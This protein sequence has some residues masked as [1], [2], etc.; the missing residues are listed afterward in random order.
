M[1]YSANTLS[2]Y[3][4]EN[5]FFHNMSK[6][7]F[8]LFPSRI[9]SQDKIDFIDKMSNSFASNMINLMSKWFDEKDSLP[10]QNNNP[11]T[12][13]KNA[14]IKRNTKEFNI[15]I[16]D[17]LD[18]WFEGE[19]FR[20]CNSKDDIE[21]EISKWFRALCKTLKTQETKYYKKHDS[22]HIK[23]E[24]IKE[25]HNRY[26]ALCNTVSNIYWNGDTD[27]TEEQLDY[28]LKMYDRFIVH[29]KDAQDELKAY[30]NEAE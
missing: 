2:E 9:V 26:G 12:V 30:F 8:I 17:Y 16:Y 25:Y 28:I 3:K 23:L 27:F 22:F 13:S 6:E 10:Q 24:T 14:W 21:Y 29:F 5:L 19:R 4:I 18:Y 20:F 1:I 7:D 15:A 11:K